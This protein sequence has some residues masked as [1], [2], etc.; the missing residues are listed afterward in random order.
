MAQSE[1]SQPEFAKEWMSADDLMKLATKEHL[2]VMSRWKLKRWREDEPEAEGHWWR[3]KGELTFEYDAGYFRLQKPFL[4]PTVVKPED[5]R[6]SSINRR[7]KTPT[8]ADAVPAIPRPR[9]FLWCFDDD[10]LVLTETQVGK[11]LGHPSGKTMERLRKR[12]LGP[13]FFLEPNPSSRPRYLYR[14]SDVAQW[15]E[16]NASNPKLKI[17]LAGVPVMLGFG[18]LNLDGMGRQPVVLRVTAVHRGKAIIRM[19]VLEAAACQPIRWRPGL[20]H[21]MVLEDWLESL[22]SLRAR[23]EGDHPSARHLERRVLAW[24]SE[25]MPD[26]AARLQQTLRA[27]AESL[28]GLQA[29]QERHQRLDEAWKDV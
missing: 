25:Q 8:G 22:A 7:P 27:W 15:L 1:S 10:A 18:P 4:P 24:L 11:G 3:K 20:T 16:A 23:P 6:R 9:R 28:K 21:D 26:Q 12:G 17:H 5:L 14:S 2:I 29:S 19:P 13:P